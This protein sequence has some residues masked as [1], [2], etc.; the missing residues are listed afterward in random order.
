MEE[1]TLELELDANVLG[2]EVISVWPG[3]NLQILFILQL[4]NQNV[5]LMRTKISNPHPHTREDLAWC[6][7][8]Y[9]GDQLAVTRLLPSN[10]WALT[11]SS[12][13]YKYS[14]QSLHASVIFE[15]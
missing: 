15:L 4:N 1:S 2:V 3:A 8:Q 13:S 10:E 7:R 6:V 9:R 11:S 12:A 5:C 14:R